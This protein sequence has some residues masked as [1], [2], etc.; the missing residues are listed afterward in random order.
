MRRAAAALL[1]ALSA[2]A[3]QAPVAAQASDVSQVV[4]EVREAVQS[5]IP[6]APVVERPQDQ[7]SPAAVAH[8]VRWEI[9]SP[10]YYE[11][12]L[13]SPI[14]PGGASGV[15]WCIG[16]DGGH[17]SAPVIRRDW[18]DHR[19]LDRLATTAGITGQAAKAALPRYRDI[20]TRFDYCERI[21]RDVTL[22]TYHRLARRTFANG[23]ELLP[24]DVQGTLTGTVYNRGASMVGPRRTEMVTLRDVCV[25]HGDLRC[26]AT[27]YRSMC[28]IWRGTPNEAGLCARYKDAARIVEE[29]K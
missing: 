13:R 20:T 23:W 25:P 5:V 21:F 6:P 12:R 26:I 28:R 17:Q 27:Q 3:G 14:W 16:Y 1:L 10:S 15:T 9:T 19:A 29:A 18:A 7:V 8:I 11:Q 2:C 22:P 4:A 24:E